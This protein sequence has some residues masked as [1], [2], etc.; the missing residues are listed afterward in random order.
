MKK[1]LLILV[2]ISFAGIISAQDSAWYNLP[3]PATE[4]N[5]I[6]GIYPARNSGY[7]AITEKLIHYSTDFFKTSTSFTNNDSTFLGFSTAAINKNNYIINFTW[8]DT[9]LFI[10]SGINTAWKKI[11]SPAYFYKF[12]S[13]S[14]GT[15]WGNSLDNIYKSTDNGFNW[16]KI[17]SEGHIYDGIKINKKNHIY[18]IAERKIYYSFDNGNNWNIIIIPDSVNRYASPRLFVTDDDLLLL[19]SERELNL[20]ADLG[21]TWQKRTTLIS[22][23]FCVFDNKGNLF[24]STADEGV[25]ISPDTA[26]TLKFICKDDNIKNIFTINGTV[27][28]AMYSLYK[29]NSDFIPKTNSKFNYPLSKENVWQY[30]HE[31]YSDSNFGSSSSNYSLITVTITGDTIINDKRFYKFSNA[32]NDWLRYSPEDNKVYWIYKGQE[33]I[34]LDFDQP[35]NISTEQWFLNSHNSWFGKADIGTKEYFGKSFLYFKLNQYNQKEVEYL[36]DLGQAS[37]DTSFYSMGSGSYGGYSVLVQAKIEKNGVIKEYSN[38]YFPEIIINPPKLVNEP[39]F[40]FNFNVKHKLN[41]ITSSGKSLVFIDSVYLIGF[42]KKSDTIKMPCRFIAQNLEQTSIFYFDTLLSDEAL[43]QGYDF[44]FKVYA[45]DKGIISRTSVMPD[46]GYYCVHYSPT[47]IKDNVA[48]SKKDFRLLQNF[49]NPANPATII[50][51]SIPEESRVR[52]VIYNSIGQELFTLEDTEKPAGNYKVIFN[53]SGL[54]SGVYFY[55]ITAG[56]FTQVRKLILIK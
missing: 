23:I 48:E 29:Y 53:G 12:A 21:K 44:Y 43:K 30:I 36:S 18:I 47:G 11:K 25:Y 26:R 9:S 19:T 13:D 20:S 28:G 40:Q 10:A 3:F 54:P 32:P 46:T 22:P 51:Y 27:F 31:R 49:P 6:Y 24:L 8:I 15:F 5:Y 39:A 38:P 52:L 2:F 42:F 55:K 16:Q 14:S 1:L 56:T 50:S 17:P 34:Y 41:R 4:R 35:Q 37:T 33:S 45:K 7:F